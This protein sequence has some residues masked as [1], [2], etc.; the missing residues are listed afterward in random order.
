MTELKLRATTLEKFRR[1][2]SDNYSYETEESLIETLSG[3]FKGNEYTRVGTA[4]HLIVERGDVSTHEGDK[5]IVK[6][7]EFDIIFNQSH[8]DTALAYKEEIKGCFHE[9]RDSKTYHVDGAKIDISGGADVI[10]GIRLRD[11]KTKYSPMRD[12]ED[13][14]DSYQW[15]VYCDIFELPEFYFD[16]FEFKGYKKEKH[17]YDVSSLSIVRHDP[18]QCLSYATMQTDIEKMLSKF[19]EFVRFK[20]LEYLFQEIKL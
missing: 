8:V 14:T 2:M 6:I 4:F 19:L 10:M 12:I 18:I 7:D 11:I 17:G 13:Y 9:I 1:F 16:I 20:N 15:R 3:S 5:R